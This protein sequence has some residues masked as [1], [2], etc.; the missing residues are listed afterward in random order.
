[1]KKNLWTWV[2][3]LSILVVCVCLLPT[4]AQAASKSDLTFAF[5][6]ADNSYEVTDCNTS[7]S[8]EL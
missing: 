8:G 5:I 1:M 3:T 2:I 4:K 6:V 7:A